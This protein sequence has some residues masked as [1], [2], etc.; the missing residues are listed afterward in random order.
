MLCEGRVAIVTGGSRG[1]GRSICKVLAR[2]GERQGHRDHR[3]DRDRRGPLRC[4][5]RAGIE[6]VARA[7]AR[8]EAQDDGLR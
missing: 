4:R 5:H 6:E 8:T 1:L 2:E 7:R 3:D